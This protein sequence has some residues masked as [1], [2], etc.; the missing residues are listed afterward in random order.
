MS[1]RKTLPIAD[2][3]AVE[4][5]YTLT[6]GDGT[7]LDTTVGGPPLPYLHGAGNIV[8]GLE[9]ELT[10]KRPGERV[11]AV[12]SA[13]EGYGEIDPDGVATEDLGAFPPGVEVG[14]QF[15]A[16]DVS[17]E[18]I[19]IWVTAIDGSTVTIDRNHPLAG[20]E[21]HFDVTVESVRRATREELDHGHVHG[22]G[23]HHHP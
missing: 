10:G 3:Y 22:P 14:M 23:G 15:A 12:V 6:A 7:R 1:S 18:V 17:G 8:P 11:R 16:E 20:K 9:R 5:H 2:G 21:L 19:P 13:A 4:I